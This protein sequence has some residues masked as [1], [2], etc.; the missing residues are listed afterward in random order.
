MAKTKA[1]QGAEQVTDQGAGA[2]VS[3]EQPAAPTTKRYRTSRPISV[4]FDI[5]VKGENIQGAKGEE[6]GYIYFDVPSHLVDTF[7]K[8]WHVQVGNVVSA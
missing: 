5:L 2:V 6:K 8:H 7:E 3:E 4:E 1:D